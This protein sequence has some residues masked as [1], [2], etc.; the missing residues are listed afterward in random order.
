MSFRDPAL[1]VDDM[2]A[3]GQAVLEYTKGLDRG[4]FAANRLVVDAVLHNL[5]IVGEAAARLPEEMCIRYPGIEWP[6]IISFRNIVVH[7][8]FG[9]DLQLVWKIVT[10]KLP[11]FLTLLN[12][13]RQ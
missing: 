7:Q 11:G 4:T 12:A 1:L 6:K 9:V 3:A 5:Q 13:G 2:L 10:D 8:Y